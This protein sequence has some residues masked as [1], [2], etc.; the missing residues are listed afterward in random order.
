MEPDFPV[1]FIVFGTPVSLQASG[2]SKEKWKE[3]V[4]EA[5]NDSLP[6]MCFSFGGPIAIDL[7][8]FP[9]TEMEGDIDNIVKPILDAMTAH[10][11]RDD[12]Q[13]VRVTVQKFEPGQ[14][15]DFANPSKTLTDALIGNRPFTYIR[16]TDEPFGEVM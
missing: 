8:Y 11:Y 7:Y 15:A 14:P 9:S 12:R 10:I 2:N 4:R 6:E 1:E 13:V 5:S 3:R 16:I